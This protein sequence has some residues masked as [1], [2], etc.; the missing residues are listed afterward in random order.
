[1]FAI[2]SLFLL[3]FYWF[4]VRLTKIGDGP[5]LD[6][7]GVVVRALSYAL[8]GPPSGPLAVA[9]AAAT[10]LAFGGAVLW[11]Q[12]QKRDE[13]IFL[14]VVIFV[15]PAV[16]YWILRPE[17][18]FVR[19]FLLC[20]V[21]GWI[22][23]AAPLASAL[24]RGGRWRIAAGAMLAAVLLGNGSLIVR[25][26]QHGRGDYLATVRFI[27]ES[28]R[29]RLP[30]VGSDHRF[31]NNNLIRFYNRYLPADRRLVYTEQD[32]GP[33]WLLL[34]RIGPLGRFAK[35]LE[36]DEYRYELVRVAAYSDL[37]GWHW[38]LYQRQRP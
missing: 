29:S 19:Y 22:A 37:S 1:L 13:W 7:E 28:A 12:R 16:S 14:A 24:A 9:A 20:S 36:R 27:A 35:E 17:V 8:G 34:H 26:Y 15:S 31:R 11:W 23:L 5:V 2:P 10:G 25:F 33:D 21:F 32:E 3:C 4:D 38:L 30:T 18:F 6:A